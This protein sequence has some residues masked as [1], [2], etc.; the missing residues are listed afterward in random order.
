MQVQKLITDFVFWK[1]LTDAEKLVAG[2]S[3]KYIV[4][5]YGHTFLNISD[6]GIAYTTI[7]YIIL[8]VVIYR[9]SGLS[10]DI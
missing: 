5:R 1:N 8:L 4:R 9:W 7:I 3:L 10:V 6:K 2:Q